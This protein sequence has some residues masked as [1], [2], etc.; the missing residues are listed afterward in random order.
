M[1][2]IA[3]SHVFEWDGKKELENIA[4]HGYSFRQAKEVFEDPSAIY[5][6]DRKHSEE[7]DRYFAVG[8]VHGG[9]VLMVRYTKRENVIRIFGA[10]SWRK[11]RKFYE[12]RKN[13][14]P[15]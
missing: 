4:K 12:K 8:R 11:W 3:S 13:S 5:L 9:D 10:A 2:I 15:L 6:E 14:K 7:E 1:H